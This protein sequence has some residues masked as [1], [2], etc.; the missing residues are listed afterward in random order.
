MAIKTNWEKN[1]INTC[2]ASNGFA[3][4]WILSKTAATTKD[5][6]ETKPRANEILTKKAKMPKSILMNPRKQSHKHFLF[7]SL[8]AEMFLLPFR[9]FLVMWLVHWYIFSRPETFSVV[10]CGDFNWHLNCVWSA[11]NFFRSKIPIFN[12]QRKVQTWPSDI[13]LI[14]QAMKL[15]FM[16]EKAFS[17]AW[18]NTN[19]W[20]WWIFE[21]LQIFT[22]FHAT[23]FFSR[24]L[25][26]FICKNIQSCLLRPSK[27]KQQNVKIIA[28]RNIRHEQ[29]V[30]TWHQVWV[31]RKKR[32][33]TERKIFSAQI[34]LGF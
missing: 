24:R 22:D 31:A 30:H 16:L 23:L 8:F 13:L 18:K 9:P 6:N 10:P 21:D 19:S 11:R 2:I 27:K 14:N 17:V 28:R 12:G 15:W 33:I 5:D 25:F 26:S 20:I 4:S 32:K 1:E 34:D 29:K 3:L 7:A